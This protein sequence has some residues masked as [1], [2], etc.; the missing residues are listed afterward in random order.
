MDLN[1]IMMRF[2][3]KKEHV[4]ERSSSIDESLQQQ[5]SA[6]IY[7]PTIIHRQLFPFYQNIINT[8]RMFFW[9][10]FDTLFHYLKQFVVR[11]N[12]WS[13]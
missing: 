3:R 10:F 13:L 4:S 6:I 9:T 12:I 1:S 8:P 5:Q 7:P 2:S 11:K